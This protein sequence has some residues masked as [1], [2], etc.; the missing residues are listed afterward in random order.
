MAVAD[1]FEVRSLYRTGNMSMILVE[2]NYGLVPRKS[3][4]KTFKIDIYIKK[5][6]SPS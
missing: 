4:I 3:K 2:I 5:I 6:F 1:R